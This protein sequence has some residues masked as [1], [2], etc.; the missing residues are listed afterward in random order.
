MSA[1]QVLL[2][3][4]GTT[5]IKS[6]LLHL[7]GGYFSHVRS[8]AALANRSPVPGRYELSPDELHERFRSVCADYMDGLGTPFDGVFICSEQ[9]GFVALD[10]HDRP[11]TPYISWKDERSREPVNGVD[12]FSLVTER[13]GERFKAVTGWRPGPNLPLMNVTHLGRQ[14]LLPPTCRIATLPEW[15]ALCSG[16]AL[17]AVHDTMLHGL[18]F[19]DVRRRAT[20]DELVALVEELAGVRCTFGSLAPTGSVTGTWR[21][22]GGR[23]PIYGG[24]GD[25]QW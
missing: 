23:V 2:I 16:E 18:G 6:A 15:L 8:H 5:S 25:H 9:N 22:R 17:G 19:Y 12:T 1:R 20:S 7:D 21:H 11:L 10:A 24:I 3:D 14:S 4:F 13:L